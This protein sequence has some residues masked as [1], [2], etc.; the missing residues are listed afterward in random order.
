MI[1]ADQR[2][3]PFG[4]RAS[5]LT[6]LA[7]LA[8]LCIIA[9]VV[10][11]NWNWPSSQSDSALIIGILALSALPIALT[12]LDLL[13]QR[14][15]VIE[16]AGVKLD[17]SKERVIGREDITVPA[18]IGV[19]G[20]AV[21]DSSTTQILDAL[22]QATR[23]DVV[24]VDLED[25]QA[26]WETRLLVLLAGAERLKRPDK[27]VF[28]GTDSRQAQRFQ[29]WAYARDLLPAL[30]SAN[31]QYARSL[32]S[33]RA[34]ARQADLVEA[35]SPPGP[36]AVAASPPPPVFPAGTLISRYSWMAFDAKTGLRNDLLEEQL[37]QADLGERVELLEGSMR[38]S[39]VRLKELFLPLL[40]RECLDLDWP[41]DRQLRTI[42][43][44]TAPW[45]ALTRNGGYTALVSRL[46]L[47][48]EVLKP[49]A[50]SRQSP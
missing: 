32:Q 3:W 11:T 22:R 7:L 46:T 17:F 48:A 40:F 1:Y 47:L 10:R 25:G 49:I 37:L 35:A 9:V 27:V 4:P 21:T 2:L 34:S 20:E 16:Y 42:L 45:I 29:G 28:V 6:A 44:A 36:G 39:L 13:V 18:N 31:L 33:A 8:I 15:V 41:S 14:G 26:W 30:V 38:I 23:S 24:V 43:D 50:Q 19:R 5:L 12:L